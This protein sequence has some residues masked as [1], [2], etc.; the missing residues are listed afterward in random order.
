MVPQERAFPSGREYRVEPKSPLCASCLSLFENY[1]QNPLHKLWRPSERRFVLHE[2]LREVEVCGKTCSLC[3]MISK[4]WTEYYALPINEDYLV[5]DLSEP[6]MGAVR[7]MP[8]GQVLEVWCGTRDLS[9]HVYT[10]D[11]MCA[12]SDTDHDFRCP[13]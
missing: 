7:I 1:L 11:G 3:D 13:G 9:L 4:G 8:R 10:D 2:S 6:P 12:C 5:E